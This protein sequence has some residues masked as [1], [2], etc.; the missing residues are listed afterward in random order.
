MNEESKT[1][2]LFIGKN[3]KIYC[4]DLKINCKYLPIGGAVRCSHGY[5]I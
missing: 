5:K 3:L 4:K 2:D 1:N